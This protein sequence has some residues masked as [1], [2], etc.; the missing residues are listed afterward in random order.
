MRDETE[1]D[2]PALGVVLT[3]QNGL[4]QLERTLTAIAAQTIAER[5]EVVVVAPDEDALAGAERLTAAFV[6]ARALA[7][8][9]I[10]NVDRAVAHGLL[11]SRAPF[12]ATIEDHAYPDPDW[13]EHLLAAWETAEAD[14]VSIGPAV[15][16]ANPRSRLSWAN[17]L[18]AYGQWA[19]TV[20]EGEMAGVPLHNGSFRRAALDPFA[21]DLPDLCNREGD[22]MT[23]LKAAGGRFRF[24]PRARVRHLNPSNLPSTARLRIDAGR[25]YAANRVRD[26]GWGWPKR[27]VFAAASPL[28]PLLRY[29]RLRAELFGPSRSLREARHAPD[30]VIGLIFDAIGQAAGVLV[31]MGGARDRLAVFEMDRLEHLDAADRR[32][33]APPR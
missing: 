3:A 15:T 29:R 16:N 20:P 28:V 27:L 24:A 26:E 11:A 6:T 10:D 31:G 4:A 5:L 12:V 19:E 18:L 22:I 14:C 1:T 32:A 21:A 17:I 33:F 13:A 23:R 9:P 7:V 25:L 8:G 30:L 2:T